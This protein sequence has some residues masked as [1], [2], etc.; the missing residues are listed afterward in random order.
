MLALTFLKAVSRAVRQLF[1]RK[2]LFLPPRYRD[3]RLLI[4]EVCPF[5]DSPAGRCD[6]CGC[7]VELKAPL[8][9]ET[10]P[11]NRWDHLPADI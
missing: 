7:F 4:C 9:T 5:F 1:R 2:P 11:A 3:E 8:R 6:V 10:C